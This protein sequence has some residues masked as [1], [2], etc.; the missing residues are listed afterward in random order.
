MPPPSFSDALPSSARS[1]PS[2]RACCARSP[3]RTAR[4][5]DARPAPRSL[6]PPV[7]ERQDQSI[8]PFEIE[9]RAADVRVSVRQHRIFPGLPARRGRGHRQRQPRRVFSRRVEEC[10]PHRTALVCPLTIDLKRGNRRD[11]RDV[12]RSDES[13]EAPHECEAWREK[14]PDQSSHDCEDQNGEHVRRASSE[15][16]L[17]KRGRVYTQRSRKTRSFSA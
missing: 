1:C 3:R 14:P 5:H 10:Q 7:S 4:E 12:R 8:L 13:S 16:L 15:L 2:A 17:V 11:V 9:R 6:E